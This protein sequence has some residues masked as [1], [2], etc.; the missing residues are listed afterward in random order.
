MQ[1]SNQELIDRVVQGDMR[2]I[3][4]LITLAEN[5]VPRAQQIL[6][7]LF[8]QA[9]RAHV[10]GVTGSPGAGKSTL[11]DR[12][13]VAWRK[14][15]KKVAILAVDPTSPFSGGAV[16]GDRIRMV[17]TLDYQ[18]IYIRSMATRGSL[19]GLSSATLDG[20]Q[21][22]D[23]AGFDLI[24]IET[25][26][27]GQAEVD[28]MRTADTCIVVLVPGMGDSVQAIK[29]GIL[30]IADLFVINKADRDGADH[31]HK[32]LRV[33]LSLT[34]YPAEAWKPPILRSVATS[35]EGAQE[36]CDSVD[37]HAVWLKSSS[38]G[39]QRKHHVVR[40]RIIKLASDRLHFRLLEQAQQKLDRLAQSCLDRQMDPYSA[41]EELLQS[42]QSPSAS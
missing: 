7:S 42:L 40:E 27:V 39:K 26:G 14:A 20:V 38:T 6:S 19:G 18:D 24:L 9:G 11:V 1:F 4:R 13:A 29:A 41:V 34:E 5:R 21:V 12:L 31:L 17:Q 33:L 35:G 15:G 37:Q 8:K 2:A 22:L 36:I 23:A 16:L 28:I 25:V 3:A 32:D 30:E 10:V